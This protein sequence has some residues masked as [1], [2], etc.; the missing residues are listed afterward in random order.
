[1]NKIKLY[2]LFLLTIS[3]CLGCQLFPSKTAPPKIIVC[4]GD[5]LTTC[6]GSGGR[7][8]D[9]LSDWL[10]PDIVITSWLHPFATYSKYIKEIKSIPIVSIAEGS[11]L[12][13]LPFKYKGIKKIENT[14][15]KNVN[16]FIYGS[17]NMKKVTESFFSMPKSKVIKNGYDVNSFSYAKRNIINDR[18]QLISVGN[19]SSVKGH[20]VLLKAMM[21]LGK[22]YHLQLRGGGPLLVE[23][24]EFV[25]KNQL[26]DRVKF[27]DKLTLL[28][29]NERLQNCNLYVQPS[30]SEGLP[31]APLEA[32]ACGLPVVC[33]NVGGMP[34]FII[35]G[36]NGYLC[37]SDSPQALAEGIVKA[38]N[39]KWD[40]KA[41]AEWVKT[42]FSW[43]MWAREMDAVLRS[44]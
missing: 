1:M 14:I 35:G 43:D 40:H 38:I 7:Y 12:L 8:T 5:S 24:I 13:I 19:L 4:I 10:K 20:D 16:Y 33:T 37:N 6:G 32:M 9:F 18:I 34:E 3:F 30:R 27:L 22:N 25:K 21:L 31:A 42:N 41:I 11:D 44:C 26:E 39:T 29:L 15:R 17:E 2:L 23:Y 28:E 36:F